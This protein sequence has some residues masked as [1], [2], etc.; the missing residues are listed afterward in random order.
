MNVL[1]RLKT[2]P[3]LVLGLVQAILALVVAL[4]L[5]L[6][7]DQT[8]AVIALV[9]ALVGIANALAVHPFQWGLAQG[10]VQAAMACLVAFGLHLTPQTQGSVL[11]VTS[12]IIAVLTR[13]LVTP[14]TKRAPVPGSTPA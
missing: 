1:N 3:A 9:G 7:K 12:A 13:Q 8:G 4:G 10:A 6:S 14:E 11:A 5:P 2:E